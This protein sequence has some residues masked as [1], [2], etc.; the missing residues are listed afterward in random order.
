VP[1]PNPEPSPQITFGKFENV[2][3]RAARVLSAP[4]AEDTRMPSRLVTLDLGPLGTRTSV[5]QYA[6]I[7]E[8]EL[9]GQNIV[10][11]INLGER[12][13]GKHTSQALMLG[14]PHPDSPADQAQATPLRVAS[15]VP[16]GSRVF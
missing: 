3:M 5:G 16:P 9:V 12:Q 1:L 11:C 7:D 10:V 13:I 4:L 2:D 6:L 8:A 15:N 14:V